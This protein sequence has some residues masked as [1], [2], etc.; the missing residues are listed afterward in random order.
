M[1]LL[2]VRNAFDG[3]RFKTAD[4]LA[5]A[6]GR[7][8]GRKWQRALARELGKMASVT[9]CDR[10]IKPQRRWINKKQVRVYD[11]NDFQ[12]TQDQRDEDDYRIQKNL[13]KLGT[14]NAMAGFRC[15]RPG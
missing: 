2:D 8:P 13:V 3:Q 4:Q 14:G 15:W 9:S 5:T 1:K 12:T 11:L 7:E 10:S 6:L